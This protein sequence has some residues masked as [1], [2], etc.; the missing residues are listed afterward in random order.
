MGTEP[1]PGHRVAQPILEIS[2]LVEDNVNTITTSCGSHRQQIEAP[3]QEAVGSMQILDSTSMASHFMPGHA[4]KNIA[5]D[6]FQCP[7]Q[8]TQRNSNFHTDLSCEEH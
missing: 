4:K 7:T 5:E 1:L 8:G 3:V 2:E 6:E